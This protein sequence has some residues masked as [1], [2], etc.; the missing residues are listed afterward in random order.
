M[1]RDGSTFSSQNID[2]Y[3]TRTEELQ[4]RKAEFRLADK[5]RTEIRSKLEQEKLKRKQDFLTGFNVISLKLKEMY[6]M[7]TLGGDA[8]LELV[9][10]YDPFQ[11]GV[12]FSVRP[13]LKSWKQITNLSGGEKTLAS[14]ALV[15]ALHHY[16]PTPIYFMDE[17]DAA[18]DFRNVSIIANYIKQNTKNAQFIII[19]LRNHM[20][21]LADQLVGVCKKNDQSMSVSVNPEKF[22]AGKKKRG[23]LGYEEDKKVQHLI[24]RFRDIKKDLKGRGKE[25]ILPAVSRHA[26][27]RGSKKPTKTNPT[28]EDAGESNANEE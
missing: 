16:R 26:S 19:S 25:H 15:F 20:F 24:K 23:A 18:L 1:R 4:A 5:E 9:D 6:Q 7:I 8:E 28:A 27:P 12:M 11:E 22:I 13:K 3:K 2:R 10:T 21:E 14:L 17:I